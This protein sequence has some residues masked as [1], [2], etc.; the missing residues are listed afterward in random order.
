MIPV[1]KVTGVGEQEVRK[2]ARITYPFLLCRADSV[3]EEHFYCYPTLEKAQDSARNY[4]DCTRIIDLSD[5][6]PAVI[7]D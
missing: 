4:N 1:V 7:P 3:R 2:T 6:P 5:L